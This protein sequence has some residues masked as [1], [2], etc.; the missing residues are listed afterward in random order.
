MQLLLD[1]SLPQLEGW[2]QEQGEPTYRATQIWE[3]AYQRGATT[4]Q[5]MTSLPAGLRARLEEAFV[6]DPL[7]PVSESISSDGQTRK[8]AFRLPDGE[9]IET[10]WMKY[11]TRRSVCVSTQAG[12][13]IGCVFC[14]TGQ[15]GFRRNLSAGEIVAQ[16]LAFARL[17][18][19]QGQRISNVVFMGMGEPFA[20]YDA[21]MKAVRLL[22]D[23]SGLGLGARHITIS[24]AGVVPGIR[25]F[26]DEGT[27]VRLAISLHAADDALR[28]RLVPLNRAYPIGALMDAVRYYVNK[29][30]RRVTFEYALIAGVNDRPDQARALAALLKDAKAHV[31]LIPLNP[32]PDSDLKASPPEAVRRFQATLETEG[33]PC[34]VR[35]GRGADIRAAC[36][37]LRAESAR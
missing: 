18:V 13:G 6:I 15:G 10:V 16:V 20:N 30:G 5:D 37:Q 31:N 12:C 9:I 25:R 11:E 26:A 35:L 36:G 27:Q 33:I 19:A 32:T 8:L 3:W 7:E 4:F 14:A 17:M 2:L 23:P 34:T 29:T 21:T 22:T 24:T 1:L 28:D